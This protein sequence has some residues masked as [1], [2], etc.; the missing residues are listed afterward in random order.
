MNRC[1]TI[2]R[3]TPYIKITIF[4]WLISKAFRSFASQLKKKNLDANSEEGKHNFRITINNCLQPTLRSKPPSL[5]I[6]FTFSSSP[7]FYSFPV[8]PAVAR[9][10]LST[11][12]LP[13]A[14]NRPQEHYIIWTKT[15]FNRNRWR[16]SKSH[17]LRGLRSD[18]IIIHC[19]YRPEVTE[20]D[21]PLITIRRFSHPDTMFALS[22]RTSCR[23]MI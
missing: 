12:K 22:L 17:L 23:N 1:S 19:H 6:L 13:F 4:L 9:P 2:I 7:P 15:H 16:F 18:E 10:R 11:R 20:N 14:L 5:G 8:A 3:L 21:G